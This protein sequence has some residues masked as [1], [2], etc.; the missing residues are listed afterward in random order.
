MH[1][2]AARVGVVHQDGIYKEDRFNM[3]TCHGKKVGR[4]QYHA[5]RGWK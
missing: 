3:A 2:Q 1:F 4:P 5:G